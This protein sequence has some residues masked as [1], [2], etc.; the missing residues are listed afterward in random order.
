MFSVFS[1]FILTTLFL[2]IFG[3]IIG[4]FLNVVI[5]RS[6]KDESWVKGRSKCESCGTLIHWYDNIPLLS[7]FL[8]SGKCRKCKTPIAI[9]HPVVEFLTGTLFVWWYWGGSLFF[10]ITH[11][12]LRY[13]QPL[14]WLVVGL[15]LLV[16]VCADFLYYL[17]PDE[18][19]LLLTGVTL[20]YRVALV[21]TGVMQPFDFIRAVIGAIGLSLFFFSIYFLSKKKGMGFGDVKLIFP[22]GLLMGWPNMM[23]GTLL[24][25]LLGSVVGVVLL[26]SGKKTFKQ[27]IPFGPFLILGAVGALVWGNQ[28][29]QWYFHLL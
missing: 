17:I 5:Y 25:F 21:S 7:Y 4:S 1:L 28:L 18:A 16:I 6:L 2:F 27:A 3:T 29:L 24:G 11:E 19:V 9:T 23:V 15:L 13:V 20:L 12:P 8:L 14:F 10:R 22:L 26:L